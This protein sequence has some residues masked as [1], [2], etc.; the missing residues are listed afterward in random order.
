MEEKSEILLEETDHQEEEKKPRKKVTIDSHLEKYQLLI[1]LVKEEIERKQKTR[2]PGIRNVQ[3]IKKMIEELE[4]EVP[5]V[6]KI[7]RKSDARKI[8]GFSLQ[9]VITEE[10]AEFMKIPKNSTPTRIDI[11]NAI[12]AYSHI[13]PNETKEQIL[14]WNHL[15]PEG[16]RNLQDPKNKM[17]IIPDAKLKKLLKYDKYVKDVK[18]GKVFKN[19]L[20]KDTGKREKVLVEDPVLSYSVIQKLIQVQILETKQAAKK[21]SD[22]ELL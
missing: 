13:K 3:N 5:K 14:R 22:I 20:N 18:E 6:A 1:S 15:N 19:V 11:T 8:S 12:C 4:K 21:E 16:K 9:C 7:K 17:N 2:E 10:L